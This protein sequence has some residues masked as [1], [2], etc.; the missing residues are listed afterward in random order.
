MTGHISCMCGKVKV[1]LSS[2]KPVYRLQ[3]GCCDCRQALQWAQMQGGPAASE[4]LANLWYFHN[5]FT[6][7][8]GKDHTA[9]FKLR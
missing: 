4:V 6:F 5:N 1:Q 7:I 8:H 3:C 9:W 2:A